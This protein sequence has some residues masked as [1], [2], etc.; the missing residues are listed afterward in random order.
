M[1]FASIWHMFLN[2]GSF[3]PETEDEDVS[4]QVLLDDRQIREDCKETEA[5]G[6]VPQ[7]KCFG[8]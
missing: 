1:K 2:T 5:N 7:T 3:I 8:R 4:R 6:F